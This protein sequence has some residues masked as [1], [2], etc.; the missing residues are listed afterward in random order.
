MNDKDNSDLEFEDEFSALQDEELT[1]QATPFAVKAKPTVWRALSFIL[2][3]TFIGFIIYEAS[4]RVKG[5]KG[6]APMAALNQYISSSNK[7][8][9]ATSSIEPTTSQSIQ[10]SEQLSST[11]TTRENLRLAPPSAIAVAPIPIAQPKSS[12][13]ASFEEISKAFSH[14]DQTAAHDPTATLDFP[15]PK[16]EGSVKDNQSHIHEVDNTAL[17]GVKENAQ[18]LLSM[19]SKYTVLQL[20]LDKLNHQLEQTNAQVKRLEGDL[21]KIVPPLSKVNTEVNALDNRLHTLT[22]AVN[23]ISDDL[24]V[25]KNGLASEGLEVGP[26]AQTRTEAAAGPGAKLL[27]PIANRDSITYE[28]PEFVVHAIIPGRAWLKSRK[29]QIITVAEGD[30]LGDYGKI[31]TIDPANALVRTSSGMAFK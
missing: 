6:Q 7:G 22:E 27:K 3:I 31:L 12:P 8:A 14:A 5:F 24:H 13:D 28:G 23:S 20:T 29:G 18:H 30:S 9:I 26:A 10:S 19:E 1:A 16:A 2:L 25:L 11:A 15:K 21:V 17:I 4:S